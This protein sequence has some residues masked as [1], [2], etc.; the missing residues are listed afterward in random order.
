M[1]RAGFCTLV[2]AGLLSGTPAGPAAAGPIEAIADAAMTPGYLPDCQ[3]ASVIG[4]VQGRFSTGAAG[5]LQ[6]ALALDTVDHVRQT[7]PVVSRPSSIARR[8]CAAT[9]WLSNGRRAP[10][11][12]MVEQRMGFA[13]IGWQVEYCVAGYE[14]WRVHDGQCRTVRKWW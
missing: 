9:A 8:Y 10:L 1:I 5:M 6:A 11:Y 2:L 4:E 3:D 13:S 12:Y 14:P 7:H